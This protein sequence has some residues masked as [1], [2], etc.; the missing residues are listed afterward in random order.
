M[1]WARLMRGT[2][3]R[4]KAVTFCAASAL[5]T[6]ACA[7]GWRKLIRMAP[8]FSAPISSWLGGCTLSTASAWLR[9]ARASG[10]S[11]PPAF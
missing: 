6:S 1:L 11:V 2:S 4:L 5:T 3:S 8:L 10:T 9:T 7:D